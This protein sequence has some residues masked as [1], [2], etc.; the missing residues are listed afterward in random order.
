MTRLQPSLLAAEPS[1]PKV[2]ARVTWTASQAGLRGVIN[3][4]GR[5]VERGVLPGL[6]RLTVE[7]VVPGGM[8]P[9]R[10]DAAPQVTPQTSPLTYLLGVWH[11]AVCVPISRFSSNAH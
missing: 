9:P 7:G 6:R 11:P 1:D 10:P 2:V 5:L 4:A 8:R 3:A